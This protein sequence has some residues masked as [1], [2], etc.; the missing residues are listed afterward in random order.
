VLDL[1]AAGRIDLKPTITHRFGLDD[2]PRAF[3]LLTGEDPEAVGR[4]MIEITDAA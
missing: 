1:I 2:A 4:V 3:A